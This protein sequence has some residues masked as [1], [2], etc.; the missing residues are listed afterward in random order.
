MDNGL[1]VALFRLECI[2]VEPYY[3]SMLQWNFYVEKEF[4]RVAGITWGNR[5]KWLPSLQ[6]LSHR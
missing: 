6:C 4:L 2:I 1:F 3:K 5:E